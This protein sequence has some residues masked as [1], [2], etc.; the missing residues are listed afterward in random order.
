MNDNIL[1]FLPTSLTFLQL[2]YMQDL[3][4]EGI[5]KLPTTIQDLVLTDN[6]KLTNECL[7]YL[8]TSL[9]SLKIDGDTSIDKKLVSE[10]KKKYKIY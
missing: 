3:K 8:P 4:N 5:R 1:S 9:I 10:W 7:N 6:T 2:Q